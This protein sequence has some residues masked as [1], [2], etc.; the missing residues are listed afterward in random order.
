AIYCRI[1][2]HED[3]P[4]FQ[5]ILDLLTE[6][7]IGV[8]IYKNFFEAVW[9]HI[10]TRSGIT[11]FESHEDIREKVDYMFSLGG[12][13]T[14]LD[15]LTFVRNHPILILGINNGRL[16]FLANIGKDE[17]EVAI[18]SITRGSYVIDRR[19][20]LELESSSSLFGEVNYA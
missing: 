18:E 4:V 8:F 1:I 20:L 7:K 14:M 9:T 19:T 11:T 15:T 3:I 13:G 16:G 5:K 10:K 2:K 6:R 17:I 12:D